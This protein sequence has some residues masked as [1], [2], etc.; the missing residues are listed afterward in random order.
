MDW[1]QKASIC[2]AVC[3]FLES[4]YYISVLKWAEQTGRLPA[5]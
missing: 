5:S 1:L 3:E 4:T 2:I